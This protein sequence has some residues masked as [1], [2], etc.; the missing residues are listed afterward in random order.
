M[1]VDIEEA[2]WNKRFG[3]GRVHHMTVEPNI[4]NT[5]FRFKYKPSS[6]LLFHLSKLAL[7]DSHCD[8]CRLT[9]YSNDHLRHLEKISSISDTQ[10]RLAAS[11]LLAWAILFGHT[12]T[13]HLVCALDGV[14]G[15]WSCISGAADIVNPWHCI[16]WSLISAFSQAWWI[17]GKCLL[18]DALARGH[19]RDRWPSLAM[20][21]V[22][23][24]PGSEMD[25]ML[26]MFKG[27]KRT[28]KER[29]CGLDMFMVAAGNVRSTPIRSAKTDHLSKLWS[30]V[31]REASELRVGVP[32]GQFALLSSSLPFHHHHDVNIYAL[33]VAC[34]YGNWSVVKLIC[35]WPLIVHQSS[36]CLL[37]DMP[38]SISLLL[39]NN[40]A[41]ALVQHDED[42]NSLLH[43]AAKRGHY[44]VVWIV[45]QCFEELLKAR[46][47][48]GQTALHMAAIHKQKTIYA[49]LRTHMSGAVADTD[50]KSADAY[51]CD[52]GVDAAPLHVN[53][54]DADQVRCTREYVR[55]KQLEKTRKKNSWL[56][57]FQLDSFLND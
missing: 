1:R 29:W 17:D 31:G 52:D 56:G 2:R 30:L 9:E 19:V 6:S 54:A 5:L 57:M 23:V 50:G 7:I 20:F 38:E 46:N 16:K 4:V 51:A 48:N 26:P 18:L 24:W 14:R 12:N 43:L 39:L 11:R 25:T 32:A 53:S 55:F 27:K 41:N 34:M 49:F 45:A 28:R 21:M 44:N 42:G 13:I 35:G 40:G 15:L 37:F 47:G 33:D 36:V 3:N 10:Q 22:G 8:A